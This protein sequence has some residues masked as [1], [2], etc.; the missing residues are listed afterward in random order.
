MHAFVAADRVMDRHTATVSRRT[1]GAL[2]KATSLCASRQSTVAPRKRNCSCDEI[3]TP[4]RR[5]QAPVP[6]PDPGAA[7]AAASGTGA[8]HVYAR[9]CE[10]YRGRR[11]LYAVRLASS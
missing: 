6:P 3:S 11:S 10:A 2:T 4:E 8:K 1:V 9:Q 5:A 7:T